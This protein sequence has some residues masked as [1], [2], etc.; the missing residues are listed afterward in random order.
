MVRSIIIFH[1]G[2]VCTN[3]PLVGSISPPKSSPLPTRRPFVPSVPLS[4]VLAARVPTARPVAT[5]TTTARRKVVHLASIGHPSLVS[6]EVPQ[7]SEKEAGL[8]YRCMVILYPRCKLHVGYA[9]NF[10]SCFTV[11]SCWDCGCCPYSNY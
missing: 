11:R 7:E 10:I 3:L 9:M 2:I 6:D 5:G 8:W 1:D 4:V